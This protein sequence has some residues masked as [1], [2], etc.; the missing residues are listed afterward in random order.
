[1]A[2]DELLG[3]TSVK[4]HELADHPD[5]EHWLGE[6]WV[7]AT[8]RGNGHGR[9]LVSACIEHARRLGV[10]SLYLYT[11]DQQPWCYRLGWCEIGQCTQDG[12]VVSMVRLDLLPS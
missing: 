5:K 4:R 1:L 12:E 3:T 9:R 11:P 2:D 7:A 10:G 6:V 8:C